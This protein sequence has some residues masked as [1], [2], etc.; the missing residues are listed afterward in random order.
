MYASHYFRREVHVF[1]LPSVKHMPFFHLIL[2]LMRNF[3]LI[4]K[5]IEI[6]EQQFIII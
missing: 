4:Q 2:Y 3:F 5:R 1:E 6:Y